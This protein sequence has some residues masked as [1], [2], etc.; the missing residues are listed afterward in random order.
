ME[1]EEVVTAIDGL[2]SFAE[3]TG[4]VLAAHK[5]VIQRHEEILLAQF[6]AGKSHFDAIEDLRKDMQSLG[7]LV[8]AQSQLL[9]SMQNA[10]VK[11]VNDLGISPEEPPGAVN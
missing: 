10:L 5:A 8:N 7:D 6:K 4:R 9:R 1:H 11:I 3:E 2:A